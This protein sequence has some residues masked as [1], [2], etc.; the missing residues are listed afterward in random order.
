MGVFCSET[1]DYLHSSSSLSEANPTLRTSQ[2]S[3]DSQN[4]WGRFLAW[5]SWVQSLPGSPG[6][7]LSDN[8]TSPSHVSNKTLRLPGNIMREQKQWK[9]KLKD[10]LAFHGAGERDEATQIAR[11]LSPSHS[12]MATHLPCGPHSVACCYPQ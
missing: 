11:E 1:K 12:K 4:V 5:L 3:P 6:Q 8:D 9:T 2:T 10:A 7:V